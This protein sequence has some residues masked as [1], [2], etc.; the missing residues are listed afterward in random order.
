MSE[1]KIIEQTLAHINLVFI[2]FGTIGNMIAFSLLI[3]K[4]VRKYSCMRYLATL[5]LIDILCLYTWNFSL[6]YSGFTSK[7]IEF[8]GQIICRLFSFFCYFILQSS[9]WLICCIGMDR[10]ITILSFKK[11]NK[12][13]EILKNTKIVT[14]ST[15]VAFFLINF[16]V[17][18]IN[19][20][21]YRELNSTLTYSN[22]TQ[23]SN[24]FNRVNLTNIPRTRSS[25]AEIFLHHLGHCA[26]RLVQSTAVFCYSGREFDV[27]DNDHST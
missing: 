4:N 9:S 12:L 1:L 25:R 26:H 27:I 7:K 23:L 6:V 19:A 5:T 16:A 20:E 22:A 18:I 2:I 24:A 10:V 15:L 17:L 14:I 13:I 3:R 8:E 21:P 11:K